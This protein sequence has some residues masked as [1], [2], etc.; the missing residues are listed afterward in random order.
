MKKIDEETHAHKCI[1]C[2]KIFRNDI[3]FYTHKNIVCPDC[4]QN[5]DDLIQYVTNL[6]YSA[7]EDESAC[8]ADF[9]L[10]VEA[11]TNELHEFY[12]SLPAKVSVTFPNDED[13]KNERNQKERY[14][15]ENMSIQ[16][17]DS[18][19]TKFAAMCCG[20]SF[21]DAIVWINGQIPK[22]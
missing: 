7:R 6:L 12:A 13:C 2:N 18:V 5:T 10:W 15:F 1:K 16:Y 9:D 11:R 19:P 21:Y 14:H 3:V 8:I 20:N 22:K 4:Q 17:G